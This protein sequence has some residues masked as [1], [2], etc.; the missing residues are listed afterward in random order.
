M[1]AR[2]RGLAFGAAECVLWGQVMPKVPVVDLAV[3]MRVH[4]YPA[5]CPLVEVLHCCTAPLCP[6]CAGTVRGFRT[7]AGLVLTSATRTT[8]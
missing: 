1:A 7:P 5:K 3:S 2:Y 6:D 8:S 4:E